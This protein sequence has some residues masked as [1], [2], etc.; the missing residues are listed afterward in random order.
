MLV[1]LQDAKHG[2]LVEHLPKN[3]GFGM[4]LEFREAIN[5]LKAGNERRVAAGMVFN[6]AVGV[7]HDLLAVGSVYSNWFYAYMMLFL[8]SGWSTGHALQL[9]TIC[10]CESVTPLELSN[11]FWD[12]LF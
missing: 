9:C 5:L 3:I 6:V 12:L 11:G 1:L 7:S 10:R 8:H 2:H 4:G